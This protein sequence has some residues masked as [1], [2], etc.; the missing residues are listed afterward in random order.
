MNADGVGGQRTKQTS[1][2][3]RLLFMKKNVLIAISLLLLTEIRTENTAP[4]NAMSETGSSGRKKDGS[5]MLGQP[6][7]RRKIHECNAMENSVG[8]CT[9]SGSI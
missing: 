4:M 1:R 6:P 9:P 7:V 5:P 2:R 8:G 3:N